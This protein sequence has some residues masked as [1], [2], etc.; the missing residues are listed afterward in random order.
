MYAIV[1]SA[2]FVNRTVPPA[3]VDVDCLKC[4]GP[5]AI[6]Y[7]DQRLF[8]VCC[9]CEGVVDLDGPHPEG[10]LGGW[11]S[12]PAILGRGTAG[13]IHTAVRTEVFHLVAMR[14][15][16][17]CPKCSGRVAWS[18]HVCN[19]HDPGPDG[20]CRTCRRKFRSAAEFACETCKNV[21]I[22]GVGSLALRHPA[23]IG[24]FWDHG[25]ALGY[26]LDDTTSRLL[27]FDD[28]ETE[29]TSIQPPR[30]RV[31]IRLQDD[32]IRLT[33][34]ESL[35]VVEVSEGDRSVRET[36]TDTAP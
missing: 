29:V 4:G 5:T 30:V 10:T 23:A 19:D 3:E 2:G 6:T 21:G 8:H 27:E 36:D 20:A 22:I 9:E 7:Q 1:A 25:I 16:G 24:F 18:L 35:D 17:I 12:N 26:D 32:V 14:A 33:Y 34:D 31:S 11:L 28:L 15:A 13:E